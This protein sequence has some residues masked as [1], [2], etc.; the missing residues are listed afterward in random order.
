MNPC[1]MNSRAWARRVCSG[2]S[3][4]VLNTGLKR[5][6]VSGASAAVSNP[7]GPNV[8]IFTSSMTA[9]R[10]NAA[11][12][13]SSTGPREF[14]FTP[15]HHGSAASD[16]DPST[17]TGIISAAIG[18]D[19][20][21]AEFGVSPE[22]VKINGA[23]DMP[24]SSGALGTFPRSLQN[25]SINPIEAGLPAHTMAWVT[26]QTSVWRR[27]DLECGLDVTGVPAGVF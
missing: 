14:L 25:L 8:T 18:N 15:G 7:F 13:V 4:V 9:A 27:V 11:I 23:R 2:R 19:T 24:T 20:V 17:A 22:A 6:V 10:I 5:T 3:A 26:S 16:N 12:T 21:V 1:G